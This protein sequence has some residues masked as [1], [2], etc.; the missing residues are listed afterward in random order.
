MVE[1]VQLATPDILC[2]M[3]KGWPAVLK[4]LLQISLQFSLDYTAHDWLASLAAFSLP[5]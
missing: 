2:S 1:K 3:A 4:L 5:D